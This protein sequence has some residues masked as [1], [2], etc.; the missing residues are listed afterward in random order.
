MTC[1]DPKCSGIVT[2][3]DRD[4][5]M[6]KVCRFGDGCRDKEKGCKDWHPRWPKGE[7]NAT[8]TPK[9]KGGGKGGNRQVKTDL[10]KA[11]IVYSREKKV[12]VRTVEDSKVSSELAK[13][14]AEVRGDT[15]K[16]V[17][18]QYGPKGWT[19]LSGW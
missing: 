15:E 11:K 10:E 1:N 16:A 6:Q 9:W 3:K 14:L 13:W 4:G 8:S 5:G 7:T 17:D 12:S 18:A 19:R 2:H